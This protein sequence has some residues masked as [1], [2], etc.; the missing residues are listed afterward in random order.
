MAMLLT[1]EQNMLR[2]AA[3]GFLQASA[4]IDQLR[5]LRDEASSDGY[6]RDTWKSMAE[7]GWSGVLIP[8]DHGGVAMGHVAAGVIA[9]EMGRTLTASPFLSTAVMGAIAVAGYGSASQREQWLS[10][11]ADGTTNVAVAVDEDR[12]H[13]PGLVTTSAQASDRGFRISGG[14]SFVADGHVADLILVSARSSGGVR[15]ENGISLFLVPR[16]CAGLTIE[17][18]MMVDSRNSATV[19][20]DGVE[21]DFDALVGEAGAGYA[22]LEH[23]LDAGRACLAAEML[24]SAQECLAQTIDYLSTRR[25]FDRTI[26][27]FQ[28]LQHRAAHLFTE[29]E[30]GRSAVMRALQALDA[31]SNDRQ[32]I[33]SV[34]KSKV[35]RVA[36]LAAQ[37]AIQ[38]H[39]GIGMT[40]EFNIGFF[41][42]RVRVAEALYGDANFHADK[43]ARMR[44]Y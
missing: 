2:D 41:L 24:G 26:G 20:F 17:R 22:V 25:Q 32:L 8:E 16:D 15:D 4:P 38:M 34:A 21:V 27:S 40:D 3:R 36:Q 18:Q 30:I 19:Q 11:I 31:A 35:G 33:V 29:I 44:N 14:K 5:R 9:E 42:K 13:S 10:K 28:A 39:G 43:F 7:M 6:D 12:S 1:D 23:V 37:E